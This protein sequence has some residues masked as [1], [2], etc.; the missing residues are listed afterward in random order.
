M[1]ETITIKH[2]GETYILP[3]TIIKSK[4]KTYSLSIDENANIIFRVP[5]RASN[6]QV[7]KLAEEKKHWIITN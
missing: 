4:R 5:L 7:R 6:Q 1:S 3:Y 2:N